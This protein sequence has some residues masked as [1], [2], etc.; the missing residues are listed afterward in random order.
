M[1][2]VSSIVRAVSCDACAKYVC[3]EISLHSQCC[4]DDDWC[5]CEIKTEPTVIETTSEDVEIEMSNG[6]DGLCCK[7]TVRSHK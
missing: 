7:C 1:G 3:N 6:C 5:N 2:E 4:D